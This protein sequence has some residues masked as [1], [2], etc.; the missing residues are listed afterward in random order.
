TYEQDLARERF[1]IPPP[2]RTYVEFRRQSGAMETVLD[3]VEFAEGA[4][5]S[6]EVIQC[7]QMHA[8]RAATNDIVCWTHDLL[9][10]SRER[11]QGRMNNL[12]AVLWQA[13]GGSWEDA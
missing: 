5:L 6:E 4:E 2:L 12:V 13:W 10:V 8:L 9:S 11:A 3:L 7:A 1:G